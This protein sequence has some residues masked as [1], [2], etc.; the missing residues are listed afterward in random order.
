[1]PDSLT[2]ELPLPPR[3]LTPGLCPDEER[4]AE[5]AVEYRAAVCSRLAIALG[6]SRPHWSGVK[7]QATFHFADALQRPAEQLM[8]SLESAFDAMA[9]AGLV[10]PCHVMIRL[11]PLQEHGA[12]K[13]RLVLGVELLAADE[14]AEAEEEPA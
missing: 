11:K 8:E 1:M 7:V 13:P 6:T 14:P 2:F 9:D 10:A 3:E 5:V 12:P 4:K